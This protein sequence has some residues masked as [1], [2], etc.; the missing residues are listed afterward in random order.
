MFLLGWRIHHD[1]YIHRS[2]WVCGCAVRISCKTAN[3]EFMP[4][5]KGAGYNVP[6]TYERRT[7]TARK[8]VEYARVQFFISII[9][10]WRPRRRS[11]PKFDWQ[12][13]QRRLRKGTRA[14]KVG[15]DTR[16]NPHAQH[17]ARL[18]LDHPRARARP[19]EKERKERWRE[20]GPTGNA[21]VR[22]KHLPQW[23]HTTHTRRERPN[24][25]NVT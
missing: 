8:V 11:N 15:G 12:R 4:T 24:P 17:N 18:E 3:S 13:G 5:D 25:P 21:Y 1:S 22:T 2:F 9:P 6:Q 10:G 14:S 20:V 23:T 7:G 19:K 16:P